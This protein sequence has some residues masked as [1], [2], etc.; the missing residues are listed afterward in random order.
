MHAT[1]DVHLDYQCES[2][3]LTTAG[4]SLGYHMLHRYV[5]RAASQFILSLSLSQAIY[6]SGGRSCTVYK[7]HK[8]LKYSHLLQTSYCGPLGRCSL[9]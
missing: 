7:Q 4:L 9:I 5:L 2:A 8:W 1:Q 6:S 3:A